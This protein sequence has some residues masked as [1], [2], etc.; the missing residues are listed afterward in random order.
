[1]L[2][3]S[4][5]PT[6]ARDAWIASLVQEA[7]GAACRIRCTPPHAAAA[8]RSDA[9][10]QDERVWSV[11]RDAGTVTD[12]GGAAIGA[13]DATHESILCRGAGRPASVACAGGRSRLPYRLDATACCGSV[14]SLRL[15]E[16]A[17]RY[18]Q[19]EHSWLAARRGLYAFRLVGRDMHDQQVVSAQGGLLP[20]SGPAG[21][22]RCPMRGDW[23][24]VAN[25]LPPY[26]HSLRGRDESRP[27]AQESRSKLGQIRMWAGSFSGKETP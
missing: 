14:N 10:P 8:D 17:E 19:G 16:A 24:P 11:D 6:Q 4:R 9:C 23:F 27:S 20:M 15:P 26:S 2:H 7:G 13:A 22:R 12:H 1:M 3:T 21:C 25:N 18:P 5:F